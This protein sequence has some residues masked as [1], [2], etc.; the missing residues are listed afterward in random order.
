MLRLITLRLL[1]SYFR[2]RWLYLLP[3]V[4]MVGVAAYYFTTAERLYTSGGILYV[5]NESFLGS[6]TSVR[7]APFSYLTPAQRGANEVRDLLRT[8]AFVRSVIRETGLEEQMDQGPEVVD[9]ILTEVRKAVWA[10]PIG[11]NQIIINSAH[12]DPQLSYELSKAAIDKYIQ[13]KINIDRV[14]SGTAE[15]FF[16]ELTMQY[17]IELEQARDDL[18]AYLETHPEP[19]RGSRPQTEQLEID[20]LSSILQMAGTRYTRAL[21]KDENA[22]LATSQAE[23]D[24]RQTYFLVDAPYMPVSPETSLRELAI[25]ATVFLAA[26]VVLTILGI[27]VGALLD[28]S[29][30]F[31]IDVDHGLSLAVLASVPDTTPKKRWWQRIF[32]R[33]AKTP[34]ESDEE[35]IDAGKAE[36][37]E[38][39][40]GEGSMA[41]ETTPQLAAGSDDGQE[42]DGAGPAKN[43]AEKEQAIQASSNATE[44]IRDGE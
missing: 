1:E 25:N 29:F 10:E 7:D 26:G 33:K 6:L 20:R 15:E 38:P 23:A 4:I 19:V 40:I 31:P 18:R 13:W 8:D 42:K 22:R 14:Q 27:V 11:E 24:I 12:P 28:R 17:E 5:Q 37:P 36:E 2:H 41:D 32:R 9:E 21:E 43:G 44:S 30:R 34:D 3:I 35:E 16:S 39:G